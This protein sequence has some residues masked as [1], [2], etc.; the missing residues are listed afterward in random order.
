MI[1]LI[2]LWGNLEIIY[3]YL[4]KI[5]IGRNTNLSYK[6]ESMGYNKSSTMREVHTDWGNPGPEWQI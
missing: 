2:G 1:V 4:V 5:L 6:P 3:L